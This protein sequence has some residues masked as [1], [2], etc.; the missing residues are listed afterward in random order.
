MGSE[1]VEKVVVTVD[2]QHLPNIQ[3]VRADLES[4]G[5]EVDGVMETVGIITGKVPPGKARA[6]GAVRGVSS[7]EPDG[8]MYAI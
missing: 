8:E 3:S 5:M 2:E 7:I 1:N 4:A 6:L